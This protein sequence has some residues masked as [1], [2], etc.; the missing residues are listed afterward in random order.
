MVLRPCTQKR[1]LV[2]VL[3]EIRV[4][5]TLLTVLNLLTVHE[6]LH[7]AVAVMLIKVW[8]NLMDIQAKLPG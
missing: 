3:Y 7:L 4:E 1:N 8:I 2:D 5:V 6:I